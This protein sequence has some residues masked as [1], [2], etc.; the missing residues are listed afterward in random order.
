[1][2]DTTTDR[3]PIHITAHNVSLSPPLREFVQD[4]I[5]TA[6]RLTNDVLAVDVVLRRRSL[7]GNERFSTSVRIALPGRDV[8]SSASAPDLYVAIGIVTERLARRLRKRKTRL[9]K[10]YS[11]RSGSRRAMPSI[12]R[13][14]TSV[15]RQETRADHE[16]TPADTEASETR[17]DE[18]RA[19]VFRRKDPFTFAP[20]KRE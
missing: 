8:H 17:P 19:F 1:M 10:T 7:P 5:G 6:A 18:P 2:T 9:S 11:V 4:K 3:I 16:E 13:S 14:A 15:P 12:E 20:V